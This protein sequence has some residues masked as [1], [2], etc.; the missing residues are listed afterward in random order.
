[1]L[2]ATLSLGL[3]VAYSGL[4]AALIGGS[5]I[6]FAMIVG[7]VLVL[8]TA[9]LIAREIFD[10][11]TV[12]GALVLVRIGLIVLDAARTFFAFEAIGAYANFG[13]T[14]VLTVST[15]LAAAVA[16][17]P[18]GLGLREGLAAFMAPFVNLQPAA[19]FLATSLSRIIGLAV[20][21]VLTLLLTL[22]RKTPSAA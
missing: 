1:V 11:P 5:A 6:A 8:C 17:V 15:V 10:E 4:W 3:G 13:Q 21:T 14:S 18:S 12:V 19:T 2:L 16:I 9:G 7:G 22:R 20:V